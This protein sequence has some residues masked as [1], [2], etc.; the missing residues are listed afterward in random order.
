MPLP[1]FRGGR[2]RDANFGFCAGAAHRRSSRPAYPLAYKRAEWWDKR[3]GPLAN[4]DVTYPDYPDGPAAFACTRNF[5]SLPVTDPAAIAS[6]LDHL[7]RAA[8]R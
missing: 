4:P 2:A 8:A 5:C 6:Q 7:Q 1:R 3:E